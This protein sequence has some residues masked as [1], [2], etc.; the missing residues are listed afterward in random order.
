MSIDLSIVIPAFNESQ[1]IERTLERVDRHV[2]T[3]G[4][5]YEIL[6]VDDGSSDGTRDVVE[7]ISTRR[8]AVR[9]LHYAQNRGKGHAVR[10]GMLAARGR[11]RL[12]SDADCSVPP[13]EIPRLLAAMDESGAAIAI[14][15]RYRNESNVSTPQPRWRVAWSRLCNAVIQKTLVG[16]IQDTQCGFKAFTASAARELFS[17]ARIDGWAFD[18]EILAIARNEVMKVEEVGVAWEDDPRTKVNPLKDLI[19]V[20][21]EYSRIRRNLRG[22]V[23]ERPQLATASHTA[24]PRF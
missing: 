23:Y 7:G 16:G 4:L 8:S 20:V 14:G 13:E 11:I 22:G 21:R 18:L 24:L 15:S 10:V 3:L 5:S 12:M 2:A 9:C 1:R 6:V 19:A 17:R